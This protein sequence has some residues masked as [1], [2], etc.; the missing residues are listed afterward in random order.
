[1]PESLGPLGAAKWTEL[2]SR[3]TAHD[4]VTLTTL[5]VYCASYQRWREAQIWL[6]EHGDVLEI[7]SDKGVV[8]KAQPAPKLDVAAR[9]EKAMSEAM[10]QLRGKIRLT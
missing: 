2:V 9:A 4:P 5:E 7:V 8:L 1:V 6:D 10:R 3:L